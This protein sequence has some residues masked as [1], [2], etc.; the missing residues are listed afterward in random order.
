MR[1]PFEHDVLFWI[2][3]VPVGQA[4]AVTWG[5]M[6]LLGAGCW[7]ITHRLG[8]RRDRSQTSLEIIVGVLVDEIRSATG[9]D[10]RPFLPLIGT[11]FLYI[12]LANW[13]SLVP[14]LEPP[15]ARLET[16][17][18]LALVVFG[19]SIWF[20]IRMQGVA[21]YLRTFVQPSIFMLP[22]NLIEAVTR[23]LSLTLR[24]FGNMVSGVI[25]VG[26]L[27]SIAG[28][29]I[30]IPL[31]ALDLLT[32]AVQAYI[33]ATL[34]LVFIASAAAHGGPSSASDKKETGNGPH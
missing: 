8:D 2:G 15:T 4:V 20:G 14:G 30:P 29:L 28:L 19:A 11:L 21:G 17:I 26:V 6:L 16:D 3:P 5:L 18:A 33:F 25:V 23:T 12:L 13:A 7:L 9:S 32:G 1:S 22:I 27:L 31:M 10:P 34:A 24:L